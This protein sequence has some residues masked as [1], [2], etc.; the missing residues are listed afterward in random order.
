MN[1][2]NRNVGRRFAQFEV[3]GHE[4]QPR[5]CLIILLKLK[6]VEA[7]N[8]FPLFGYKSKTKEAGSSFFLDY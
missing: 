4:K 1:P 6:K 7:K 3:I 2:Q 5:E 8:I